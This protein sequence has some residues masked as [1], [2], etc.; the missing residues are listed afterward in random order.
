MHRVAESVAP[1][2]NILPS[3][4]YPGTEFGPV[5]LPDGSAAA[6]FVQYSA[7][8]SAADAVAA[9][10]TGAPLYTTSL[11][12]QFYPAGVSPIYTAIGC[13][14]DPAAPQTGILCTSAPGVGANL[15][16]RVTIAGLTSPVFRSAISYASPTITSVGGAGADLCPT[17]G[18]Q[19]VTL[20]GT[21]VTSS[22][23]GVV[24]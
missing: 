5:T 3:P 9:A 22:A 17:E 4:C 24:R 18:G 23:V 10:I 12:A 14:V 7:N 11:G 6:I 2:V 21:Q 19:V 1:L 20:L 13:V 16:V 15:D 8:F